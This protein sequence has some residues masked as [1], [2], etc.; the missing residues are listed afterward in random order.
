M[1]LLLHKVMNFT[2]I[3]M[4]G[5]ENLSP[6]MQ[7]LSLLVFNKSHSNLV[8]LTI[9][10]KAFFLAMLTDFPVEGLFSKV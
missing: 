7:S 2:D 1:K 3:C 10:F 6:T 5:G 9:N 8:I 4:V